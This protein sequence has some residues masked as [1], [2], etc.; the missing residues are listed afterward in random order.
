MSKEPDPLTASKPLEEAAP[1]ELPKFAMTPPPYMIFRLPNVG[2]FVIAGFNAKG[3]L[4][5]KTTPELREA[6]ES[7]AGIISGMVEASAVSGE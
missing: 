1:A 3:P 7:F 2:D 5:V 4:I 6:L